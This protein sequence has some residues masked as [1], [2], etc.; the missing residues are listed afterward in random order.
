MIKVLRT[1]TFLS[2]FSGPPQRHFHRASPFPFLESH[3]HPILVPVSYYHHS[4]VLRISLFK[5]WLKIRWSVPVHT[6][7]HLWGIFLCGYLSDT[8]LQVSFF[9]PSTKL[10][11]AGQ[12]FPKLRGPCRDAPVVP[13][14]G[15]CCFFSTTLSKGARTRVITTEG[16]ILFVS[17]RFVI[18]WFPTIREMDRMGI[19]TRYT[20]EKPNV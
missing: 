1:S 3:C 12:K 9:L 14:L 18:S 19:P 10:A 6:P 8:M 15:K 4:T 20:V 13:V 17:K 11:I 16:F 5:G 2:G 7:F